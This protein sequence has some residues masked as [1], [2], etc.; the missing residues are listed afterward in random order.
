[1]NAVL[2]ILPKILPPEA[3]VQAIGAATILCEHGT[4]RAKHVVAATSRVREVKP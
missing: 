1:M 4:K 3:S 2:I